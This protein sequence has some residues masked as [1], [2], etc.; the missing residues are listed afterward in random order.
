MWLHHQMCQ[1]YSLRPSSVLGIDDDWLAYDFDLTITQFA[2][3]VQNRLDE[4][5]ENGKP[6]HDI[7]K[8]L[9]VKKTPKK[10]RQK[11]QWIREDTPKG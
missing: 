8:A 9:N 11:W 3:A 5:D 7:Y 4:R 10:P 2:I 1:M 6:T